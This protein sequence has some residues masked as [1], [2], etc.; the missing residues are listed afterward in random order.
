MTELDADV[1]LLA[2][3]LDGHLD[4]ELLRGGIR[5]LRLPH[6]QL[7]YAPAPLALMAR[8]SSG[9]RLRLHTD[10]DHLELETSIERLAR[11]GERPPAEF[12]AIDG[13]TTIAVRVSDTGLIHALPRMRFEHG[14]E[15]RSHVAFPLRTAA[16]PRDVEIWLPHNASV[17]LHCIR[18]TRNGL[19]TTVEASAPSMRPRWLRH[20]SA[21]CW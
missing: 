20:G 7:R 1:D 5:P 14:P 15:V 4:T 13:A 9:V 18:A 17:T 6:R 8:F 10:A 3:A 11:P 2:R 12:A 16:G 21:S 19:A